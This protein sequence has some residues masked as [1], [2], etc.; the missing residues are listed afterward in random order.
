MIP[1]SVNS[2]EKVAG[3]V[4][5]SIWK[6]IGKGISGTF[7]LIGK[8]PKTSIGAAAATLGAVALADKIHP[9]HQMFR[10]ETKNVILKDQN[11]IL[12]DILNQEK[13]KPTKSTGQKL[14]VPP[15]T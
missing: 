4:S 9:L 13:K 15:L 6:G 10:E 5:E 14:V 12:L 8:Y 7:K 1:L 2:F 3:P 11:R